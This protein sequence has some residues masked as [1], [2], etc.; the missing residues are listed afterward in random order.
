MRYIYIYIYAQTPHGGLPFSI[1]VLHAQR[2]F[3]QRATNNRLLIEFVCHLWS[4]NT[5]IMAPCVFVVLAVHVCLPTK[6]GIE[7][8]CGFVQF[9]FY[10]G[11]VY[12]SGSQ[13]CA[14]KRG[15]IMPNTDRTP[16]EMVVWTTHRYR[17]PK[18][19]NK[20]TVFTKFFGIDPEHSCRNLL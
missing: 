13:G 8:L 3:G 9:L 19:P 5:Y 7:R 2:L 15:S 17:T 18:Q 14:P 11:V 16:N 4:E 6:Q 20:T 10:F 12:V 1:A